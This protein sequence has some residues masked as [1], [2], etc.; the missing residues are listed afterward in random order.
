MAQYAINGK[1][2]HIRFTDAEGKKHRVAL[3]R[4]KISELLRLLSDS[5]VAFEDNITEPAGD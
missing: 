3:D 1:Y 2:V 5:L 4:E